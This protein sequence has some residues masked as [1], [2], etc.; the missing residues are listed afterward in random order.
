MASTA[1]SYH[2][3]ALE[4]IADADLLHA[5]GRYPFAMYASGLAVECMLRAFRLLNDPSFDERHDLWQLWKKTALANA[6]RESIYERSFALM[7]QVNLRWQNSF[8]FRLHKRSK[9]VFENNRP[10]AWNQRR[11]FEI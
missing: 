11:L 3:A 10:T 5:E 8:R 4:R 7:G 2:R 9:L 1:K 6:R